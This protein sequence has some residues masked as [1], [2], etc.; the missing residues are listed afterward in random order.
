MNYITPSLSG[1]PFPQKTSIKIVQNIMLH[2]FCP[3]LPRKRVSQSFFTINLML[4]LLGTS[5]V[6]CS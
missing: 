2:K 5:A 4:F 3:A 1:S 6:M